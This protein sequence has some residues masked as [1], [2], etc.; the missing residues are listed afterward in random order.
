MKWKVSQSKIHGNGVF[1]SEDVKEHEDMGVCI[2]LVEEGPDYIMYQRNTFGLLVNESKD[3]NARIV[4][5]GDDWH[6]V[7]TKPIKKDDEIVV[8]YKDYE[9]KIDLE[10]I[11][12]RK[13]VSVI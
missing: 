10:S 12:A 6:F 11:L 4:K 8:D 1:A 2:P 13:R 5:V 7:S 9:S 3:P